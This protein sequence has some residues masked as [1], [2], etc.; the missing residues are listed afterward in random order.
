MAESTE[1]AEEHLIKQTNKLLSTR[2]FKEQL[3]NNGYKLE[4]CFLDS[5][6]DKTYEIAPK[7]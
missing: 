1:L 5:T 4:C 3:R 2:E 7:R 6:K